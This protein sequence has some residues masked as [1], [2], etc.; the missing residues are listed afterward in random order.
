MRIK[1]VVF[2][3]FIFSYLPVNAQATDSPRLPDD[4][5]LVRGKLENGMDF[6][7]YPQPTPKGQ[8]NL[9]LQVHSGS[10]VED[11]DQRGIAHLVEHMLFNG[12]KD[13]PSNQVIEKLEKIGL[14]F[15]RDV[16]AFTSYDQTTY[17]INMPSENPDKLHFVMN[18]F[19]NWASEA[20]FD[21]KELDDERGVVIEEWRT[22]QNVFWRLNKKREEYTLADSRYL[23]REPIGLVDTIKN[24]SGDRV[25]AYYDTWYQ[26][27]NMTF[28]VSGD[29]DADKA[30]TLITNTFSGLKN[31]PLPAQKSDYKTVPAK[32]GTRLVTLSD[33]EYDNNSLLIMVRFP[34]TPSTTDATFI[35]NTKNNILISLFNQRM[36]DLLQKGKLHA[37]NIYADNSQLGDTYQSLSFVADAKGEQ[38]NDA[39]ESLLEELTRIDRF[40]FTQNELDRLQKND[41]IQLKN[42]MENEDSRDSQMIAEMLAA[43]SIENTPV[44]GLKTQY[45][46]HKKMFQSL[47]LDEMNARWKA[48]RAQPDVII[49][50]I[51][52]PKNQQNAFTLDSFNTLNNAVQN[53]PLYAYTL[54]LNTKPL[55]SEKPQSGSIIHETNIDEKASELFLS[56]GAKAVI[57]PTAFDD[58][59]VKIVALRRKG[60]LSEHTIDDYKLAEIATRVVNSSGLGALS[61]N[62]F[63]DWQTENLLNFTT[64]LDQ[65]SALISISVDKSKLS[66]A[67][68]LLYQRFMA[69]KINPD[70]VNLIKED[71]KN[72]LK[73]I[74]TE[75]QSRYRQRLLEAR[76]E[77]PRVALLSDAQIDKITGDQ[78]LALDKRIFAHPNAFTFIIVGQVDDNQVKTLLTDYVASLPNVERKT[79]DEIV[80]LKH[81]NESKNV[82]LNAGKAQYAE[83]NRYLTHK[84]YGLT[85]HDR[86]SLMAFNFLLSRDLRVQVRE[87]ASG[88]YGIYS[89][90]TYEPITQRFNYIM[91]FSCEP[92]RYQELLSLA[93]QVREKRIQ[94]GITNEEL[95]EYQ[96]IQKRAINIQK[97]TNDNL[98]A[99]L[100]TSYALY[101]A[102]I[103]YTKSDDLIDSLTAADVNAIAKTLFTSQQITTTGVLLPEK[104]Q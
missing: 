79:S 26:P 102:P 19:K 70:L 49:E 80:P 73:I 76:F 47:T 84:H 7:I 61:F 37:L 25:R 66:A 20:T 48:L 16:N 1:A 23:L 98:V 43:N 11:D 50:Q 96:K 72:Y 104:P 54:E 69:Q 2:S 31:H 6:M 89:N 51:I 101:D 30:K 78:L 41:L 5:K 14:R 33:E 62:E 39:A 52:S 60:L 63:D 55:L 99:L 100:T 57:V 46:L 86:Q 77:D 10:L 91:S 17:Y 75:P 81:T 59:K 74:S 36:N 3:L 92:A 88:V 12:T 15:G 44:V 9:W 42:D 8:L 21:P 18:I 83:V 28:I 94:S 103:L 65:N 35:E 53:K 85:E 56:N 22:R 27:A 24:V 58:K 38:L 40:G 45:E 34:F 64:S 82:I 4:P 90:A 13:Y 87:K 93:Q 95:Q 71:Q 67:F 29:I 68:E 97:S 32:K